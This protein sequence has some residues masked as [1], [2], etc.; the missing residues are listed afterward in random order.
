MKVDVQEIEACKR[1][2]HVEAPTEVV[3]RAWDEAYGRVQKKAKLPGF[4][5]GHVPRSLVRLHFADEVR[6]EV[7]HHLIPEVY[8]EALAEAKLLPVEEPQ[9][10][11]VALEE[12]EPLRFTAV[13]EVKPLITLGEYRGLPIQHQPTSVTEADIEQ[14]LEHLR[15]QH[16]EFSSVDRPAATGDLVTVDYT[17]TVEGE[18]PTKEQG[19]TFQTGS[20]AVLPEI[21]EACVGLAIG[22]ERE[23]P[24]RFPESHQREELRGKS[25]LVQ[26]RVVEVKAKS[27]PSLDDEFAK[28]VGE[29]ETLDALKTALRNELAH[30]REHE[31]RRSLEEKIVDGLIERH[32]FEVPEAMVLRQVA[33]LIGHVQNRMKQQGVDP[34][35]IPWDYARLTEE[36]RPSATK[37]V[38]RALLLEAIAIQEG[39]IPTDAALDT[40]VEK[41]ALASQRSP[42]ALRRVLEKSGDL[43]ELRRSLKDSKTMDFLIQH[44][45]ITSDVH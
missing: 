4:R 9:V 28:T 36:L 41:I 3:Q 23:V 25:G 26:V 42:Q 37:H 18:E 39:L 43:E 20:S 5:K 24:F 16:A 34:A 32:P 13:V 30:Q 11:Q 22:A 35:K 27:L 12:G 21:D 38:R 19:Y 10:E 1:R 6:R 45:A 14:A 44:A 2:L 31:N 8:R 33:H 7:V 15:E 17:L 29:H 40:E